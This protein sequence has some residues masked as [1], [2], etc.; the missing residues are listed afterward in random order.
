MTD[1]KPRAVLFD[2]DGVTIIPQAPFS[3]QYA[4]AHGLDPK[5]LG[6]FF[7]ERFGEAL[8]GKRDLKELLEERRALWQLQGSVEDLLKQWFAAENCRNEELVTLIQNARKNG[9]PCYLATNQEKYRTQFIK[10]TMFPGVFDAIFLRQ[11]LA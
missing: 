5:V 10:E 11:T 1:T 2:A 8:I 7:D 4:A 9:I 3:V 6:T